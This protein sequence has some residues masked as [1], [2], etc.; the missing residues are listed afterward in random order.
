M[1]EKGKKKKKE[2]GDN[3]YDKKA[4]EEGRSKRKMTKRQRRCHTTVDMC[5]PSQ[6]MKAILKTEK[7]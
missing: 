4:R 3:D 1:E 6:T 5:K 2:E 7:D